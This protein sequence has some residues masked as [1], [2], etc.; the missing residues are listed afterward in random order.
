[1]QHTQNISNYIN[2]L[3]AHY[4]A[5][6]SFQHRSCRLNH[7]SVVCSANMT[8]HV[9]NSQ[10]CTLRC[11]GCENQ[12]GSAVDRDYDRDG[13]GQGPAMGEHAGRRRCGTASSRTRRRRRGGVRSERGHDG[14]AGVHGRARWCDGA[15]RQGV[16][17]WRGA[18]SLTRSE[19]RTPGDTV[20]TQVRAAATRSGAPRCTVVCTKKIGEP[21]RAEAR[22]G[23]RR[24]RKRRIRPRRSSREFRA[25][26]PC[27]RGCR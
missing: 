22:T 8:P 7:I 2:R 16:G 4:D 12:S 9:S 3:V 19:E 24:R 1:M 26:V 18:P 14:D 5:M 27:R 21:I 13:D 23:S 17:R 10:P 6:R 20:S 15:V 11:V 25:A